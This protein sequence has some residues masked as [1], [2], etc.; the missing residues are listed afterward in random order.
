MS[1]NLIQFDRAKFSVNAYTEAV[2]AE[3]A[4]EFSIDNYTAAI[5]AEF[6][7]IFFDD[8]EDT[9]ELIDDDEAGGAEKKIPKC[10]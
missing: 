3:F 9:G 8:D 1:F 7:Q 5:E 6:L 2:E 4:A 10:F